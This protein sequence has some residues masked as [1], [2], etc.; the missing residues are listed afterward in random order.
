MTIGFEFNQ[1][2]GVISYEGTP[3]LEQ[4]D[5]RVFVETSAPSSPKNGDVWY[6][7]NATK[8]YIRRNAQWEQVPLTGEMNSDTGNLTLNGGNY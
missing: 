1:K 7:S 6:D 4:T 2:T 5:G 3:I 8:L